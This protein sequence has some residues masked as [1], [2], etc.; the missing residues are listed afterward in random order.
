MADYI[1]ENGTVVT[2]D[3]KGKIIE[4]GAV[5]VE[6]NRILAVGKTSD[7][8]RRHSA[9]ERIDARG[10][11]ILPGFV[12]SHNHMYNSLTR[13][14]KL[15]IS[16]EIGLDFGPILTRWWWP[17]IE[18]TC[19]KDDVYA[20]V[21]LASTEMV[22]R[23]ITCT[24]DLQ[25]GQ[26][27]IPGVL[28]YAAKAVEKVG[29][30]AC[31]S[32]EATDRESVKKGRLGLKE[33]EAFIKKWNYKKDSRI[34]G[35]MGVHTC[36]SCHPET[37]RKAREIAD[38]HRCGIQI[39]IAQSV[40]EVKMIREKYGVGGSVEFLD[41]LGFLGPDVN[42]AHGIYISKKE[43]EIWQRNDVGLSFNIKSNA[44]WA[45]GLAPVV[46]LLRRG[47]KVGLGVDGENIYD[48][49]ELMAYSAAILRLYHLDLSLIPPKQALE[50]ATMGGARCLGLE[51]EIG[52]LE[53]G[54]KA[55]VLVADFSGHAHLTPIFDKLAAL[56]FYVRG[57]DVDTV[58]VNGEIV[59][60][61]K[62]ILT[63]DEEKISEL[64]A[65]RAAKYQER[66]AS[67]P[68]NPPWNLPKK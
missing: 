1:F 32:F 56:A 54:K 12:T 11:V 53:A 43:L 4:D 55:D 26:N 8:K 3:G 39:H 7:V 17:K 59:V 67:A 36:F 48:M 65:K 49:F 20:G 61:G 33:N 18:D 52:S 30:R 21:L 27:L 37:L 64:A 9:E 66:A 62:R 44:F 31:L 47:C 15:S 46:D 25:E 45:N 19:R 5:A 41:K 6:G 13:Y 58:M 16:P 50:M 22:K 51:K 14:M 34:R 23:G 24:A 40:Y 29:I 38:K 42:A 68:L 60:R 35:M 10:K 57:T 2:M 28:D 63:V